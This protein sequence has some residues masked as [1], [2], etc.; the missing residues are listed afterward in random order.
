MPLRSILTRN[1]QGRPSRVR[2]F[3]ALDRVSNR[4]G[5]DI[6]QTITVSG[7]GNFVM[8]GDYTWNP[9]TEKFE[10]VYDDMFI[11]TL[12]FDSVWLLDGL[13]YDYWNSG[14]VEKM[15]ENATDLDPNVIPTSNWTI[16]I[17]FESWMYGPVPTITVN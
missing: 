14:G 4:G 3:S 13:D 1:N 12:Y 6:N 11:N 15:Y 8:N 7:A 10:Y 9:A 17:Q 16:A 5:I 2:S